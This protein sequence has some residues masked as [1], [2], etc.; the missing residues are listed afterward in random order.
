MRFDTIRTVRL[1]GLLALCVAAASTSCAQE[2]PQPKLTVPAV[3]LCTDPRPQ[4]CSEI[5]QPVCGFT[6]DGTSH[7]YSNAC[8]ACVKPEVVRSTPG[9]CKKD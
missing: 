4:M 5:Y 7:T 3:K 8:F 6:K 9:E 1:A 2:P